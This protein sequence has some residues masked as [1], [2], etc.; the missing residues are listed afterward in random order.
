MKGEGLVGHGGRI[1]GVFA[2]RALIVCKDHVAEGE[3]LFAI[4][5]SL[6]LTATASTLPP[7][8]L[9]PLK[10]MGSW[11]PLIVAIIHE[12]L[13]QDA[14]PWAPYF[15][16]LPT[17]FDTLMFWNPAELAELQGSAV[18]HKIGRSSVEETW[19]T[20]I[21][22]V[23]LSH[24]DLFPTGAGT[25]SEST[26]ELIR[27]AHMAGSLIMAYAFDI[28]RDEDRSPHAGDRSSDDEFED[29]DE[30]EPLKGMI[31][32]ADMLNADADRN[33]VGRPPQSALPM[34]NAKHETLTLGVCAG[35]TVPRR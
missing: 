30:D 16:V 19:R 4:P 35:T 34:H 6:V 1:P 11:L 14:S 24:P 22:P 29:D 7:A 33:N 31:P 2:N 17:E 20:T 13:R 10:E 26:A 8:I 15:R 5:K 23:M 27:L 12:Y 32:W 3:E 21:L 28:D 25:A 9:Q 18:V